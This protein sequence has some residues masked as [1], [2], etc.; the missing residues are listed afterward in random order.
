M[1]FCICSHQLLDK[2]SL[3]T[4]RVITN[5]V[6]RDGQ[7]RLLFTTARSFSWVYPHRFRDVSLV[8]GFYQTTKFSPCQDMS[9]IIVPSIP[10]P[11]QYFIFPFPPA[12]TLSR[13]SIS[14]SREIYVS[15][16]G[17][18]LLPSSLELLIIARLFGYIR[19]IF[20]HKNIVVLRVTKVYY[21]MGCFKCYLEKPQNTQNLSNTNIERLF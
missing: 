12:P 18:S 10:P 15:L 14:I 17:P 3:M 6:T 8:P 9:F 11:T 1:D 2:V 7:F 20:K 5:L 21:A 4:I 13:R 16:F 19:N